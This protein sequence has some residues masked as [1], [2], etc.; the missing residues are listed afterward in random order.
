M[1]EQ[2]MG[3][4]DV[5][6]SML[7]VGKQQ[8]EKLFDRELKDR[9]IEL[10]KRISMVDIE[11]KDMMKKADVAVGIMLSDAEERSEKIIRSARNEQE[12]ILK[13][14]RDGAEKILKNATK[15]AEQLFE[16]T[17]KNIKELKKM[18]IKQADVVEQLCKHLD[19][20]SIFL[21]PNVPSECDII[22]QLAD[23]AFKSLKDAQ[24]INS[25]LNML[26]NDNNNIKNDCENNWINQLNEL[27]EEKKDNVKCFYWHIYNDQDKL[28]KV[29]Q[30][31]NN[32]LM[33]AVNSGKNTV[34]VKYSHGGNNYE[35]QV[36]VFGQNDIIAQQENI[37]T[38][39]IRGLEIKETI[40]SSSYMS[41]I[42]SAK[43]LFSYA[44]A[45][46]KQYVNN[47]MVDNWIQ[48]IIIGQCGEKYKFAINILHNDQYKSQFMALLKTR[49]MMN[50]STRIMFAFHGTPKP[51][52]LVGGGKIQ[53]KY[54]WALK[55]KQSKYLG[56]G[57][58]FTNSIEYAI[59]YSKG[60]GSILGFFVLVGDSFVV[61]DICYGNKM[62]NL[63]CPPDEKDSCTGTNADGHDGEHI[64][65]T[66]DDCHSLMA[67]QIKIT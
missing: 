62:P 27:D 59:K 51:Q 65:T 2:N 32:I 36:N 19:K 5:L 40:E 55:K 54:S 28:I 25:H 60:S 7:I 39:K 18:Q 10:E 29:S 47:G 50:K 15:T 1:A 45:I 57:N 13:S 49:K 30:K 24:Q 43:D 42:E 11:R 35:T 33:K 21:D 20:I 16:D 3:I 9:K 48:K 22:Q 66:Y 52:E 12:L 58:Y 53:A 46:L 8:L 64:F 23:N 67:C 31:V 14:A 34:T 26:I 61:E 4:N 38:G 63:M 37:E 17:K 41:K 44:P 6:E 56:V